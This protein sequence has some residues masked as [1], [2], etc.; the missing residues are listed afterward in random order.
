MSPQQADYLRENLKLQVLNARLD[1]LSRNASGYRAD[2]RAIVSGLHSYFNT[3]QA[4]VQMA[5][6]LA[7][8]AEQVDLAAQPAANLESLAALANLGLGSY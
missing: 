7:R 8:Q 6:T 5:L 4:R 3:N 2:M 1:L